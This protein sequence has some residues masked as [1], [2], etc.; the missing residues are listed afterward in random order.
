MSEDLLALI[1]E[2]G[3]RESANLRMLYRLLK[4]PDIEPEEKVKQAIELIEIM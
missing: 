1:D 3:R 4:N 2:M